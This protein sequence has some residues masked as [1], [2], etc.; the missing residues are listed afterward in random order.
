VTKTP[1]GMDFLFLVHGIFRNILLFMGYQKSPPPPHDEMPQDF[2][3]NFEAL[4]GPRE[5][6]AAAIHQTYG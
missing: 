4:H 2:V 6:K 5:K 1:P 3:H